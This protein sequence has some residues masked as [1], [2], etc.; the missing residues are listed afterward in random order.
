[1]QVTEKK[2]EALLSITRLRNA[3]IGLDRIP[4]DAEKTLL[5][6]VRNGRY[7]DIHTPSFA[8][9]EQNLGKAAANPLHQYLFM[10]VAC[11]TLCA[12]AAIEGGAMP[13][14]AFNLSDSMLYMLDFCETTE[15]IHSIYSLTGIM[16]AKLV[17]GSK[18]EVPVKVDQALNY[19]YKNL[20]KKVTVQEIASFLEISPSYLSHLFQEN[21]GIPLHDYIQREKIDRACN[22]LS[23]TDRPLSVIASYLGFATPSNFALVFRKWK[24]MTPTEYRRLNYNEIF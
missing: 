9:M 5:D 3:E 23:Q 21:M 11:I 24:H 18:K 7:K 1:M 12:R 6:N 17:A 10:T 16:F 8:Q 14:E 15:E 19:I 22:L 4:M 2:I 20:Y 13:E